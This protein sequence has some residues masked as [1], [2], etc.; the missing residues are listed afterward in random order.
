MASGENMQLR[1]EGTRINNTRIDNKCINDEWICD[2]LLLDIQ[3]SSAETLQATLYRGI[4]TLIEEGRI[5][6]GIRLPST[7][8][9]AARLPVGRNTAMLVM[10]QLA[11]D[12]FVEARAGAGCFVSHAYRARNG[13]HKS[14]RTNVHVNKND[15][16]QK[17]EVTASAV[18]GNERL[19]ARG[20]R[21]LNLSQLRNHTDA[22]AFSPGLPSLSLF[23]WE[24]WR[25]LQQRYWRRTPLDWMRYHTEGG[26]L[27]L[28]EVL[29][30]YLTLSRSVRCTPNQIVITQGA[31]QA[32]S[33]I[34]TLLA[35]KGETVWFENPGYRGARAAFEAANL[36]VEPVPV[37][38]EGMAPHPDLPEPSLI[39]ITPS[40]QYPTAVT[41]SMAR[42]MSLLTRAEQSGAWI[43]EDDYDSEFRY[44]SRPLASLQGMDTTERVI[45]VGTFS[46]VMYPGLGLGYMVLPAS[47]ADAFRRASTRLMREIHYPLQA[48]VADFIADGAFRQ[49][50]R[51]CRRTYE[52]R[53]SLLRQCLQPAVDRGLRLSA[54]KAGMHLL[55]THDEGLDESAL[56]KM[57]NAHNV[58]LS[59]YS[60]YFMAPSNPLDSDLPLDSTPAKTGT[61][62]VLG[63]AAA[64]EQAL[65]QA[66]HLLNQWLKQTGR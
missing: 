30:D 51:R 34:A 20:E 56:I 22:L 39:Y 11:H 50:I 28:R 12:G 44:D 17:E 49:H 25:R 53:Q 58:H 37:D 35:E 64:D 60:S 66:S 57:G 9:L 29:C 26:L 52:E 6:A 5:T 16:V 38:N 41:L 21:L 14:D 23:P 48:A 47:L 24:K 13:I 63:Y 3:H 10:E 15:H 36:T 55:A 43:I 46:K 1:I 18:T 7:R 54:G 59:P 61:G 42:R 31:Q 33:L 4:R 19:S 2:A 32:F 62:L 40:H 27:R 45:Y 65:E 8:R